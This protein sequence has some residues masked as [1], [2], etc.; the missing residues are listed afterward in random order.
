MRVAV[1]RVEEL[2]QVSFSQRDVVLGTLPR[3]RDVLK[4]ASQRLPGV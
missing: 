3:K 4:K 2:G 1:V